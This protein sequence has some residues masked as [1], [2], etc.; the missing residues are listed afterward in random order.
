MRIHYIPPSGHRTWVRPPELRINPHRVHILAYAVGPSNLRGV[1]PRQVFPEGRSGLPK[2]YSMKCS[3]GTYKAVS[4]NCRSF[5]SY[6]LGSMLGPPDFRK[7][8]RKRVI[9]GL[10]N[11]CTLKCHEAL[12]PCSSAL[13][14]KW[15]QPE[16][17]GR[18]R[19]NWIRDSAF[20]FYVFSG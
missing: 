9:L 4:R 17:P 14:S 6:Y 7:H 19:S 20:C 13:R 1:V 3:Y 11:G 10:L 8:E 18:A 2:P 5:L 16:A 15:R 12:A